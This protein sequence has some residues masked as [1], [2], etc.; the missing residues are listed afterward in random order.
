MPDAVIGA[1][2]GATGAVVGALLAVGGSFLTSLF[3]ARNV[4]KQDQRRE[5]QR[6]QQ[7]GEEAAF[8]ILRT[9]DETVTDTFSWKRESQRRQ[10]HKEVVEGLGWPED[11]G[12]SFGPRQDDVE[13]IYHRIRTLAI[14]ISDPTVRGLSEQVGELLYFHDDVTSLL[15][16]SPSAFANRLQADARAVLGAYRRGDAPLPGH[17]SVDEFWAAHL[18][19]QSMYEAQ[20]EAVMDH[21]RAEAAADM[22]I[23]EA[24][25]EEETRIDEMVRGDEERSGL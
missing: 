22:A 17:P 13:P 11:A 4:E 7:R 15:E 2:I 23:D 1:L 9:V 6:R 10:R 12:A 5:V 8:E 20:Y 18:E 24:I 16:V 21:D 3:S 19:R 14:D 25:A